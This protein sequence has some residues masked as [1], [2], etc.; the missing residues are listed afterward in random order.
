[1]KG[2]LAD[3]AGSTLVWFRKLAVDK[4]IA[5]ETTMPHVFTLTTRYL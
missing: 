5:L 3:L 1:M 4:R 2:I